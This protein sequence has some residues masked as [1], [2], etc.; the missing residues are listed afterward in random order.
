MIL[1]PCAVL[2]RWVSHSCTLGFYRQLLILFFTTAPRS[3]QS[4]F[5]LNSLTSRRRGM[6]HAFSQMLFATV[7]H[8]LFSGP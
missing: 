3:V 1:R 6:T 4:G 8:P 2:E 5:C 7:S